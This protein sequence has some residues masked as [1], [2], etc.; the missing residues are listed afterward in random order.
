MNPQS[1][2]PA[3]RTAPRTGRQRDYLP[4]ASVFPDSGF[5]APGDCSAVAPAVFCCWATQ[6]H[7]PVILGQ[8]ANRAPR[9]RPLPCPGPWPC[10]GHP[11]WFI[12]GQVHAGCCV[13]CDC[14]ACFCAWSSAY[15]PEKPKTRA[16]ITTRVIETSFFIT[17]PF[18][19]DLMNIDS[20][21]PG[22]R[23]R[24]NIPYGSNCR[25]VER[26]SS[27]IPGLP[28][29]PK[30]GPA[31]RQHNPRRFPRLPGYMA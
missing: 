9:P 29:Q 31:S 27:G 17:I 26:S 1:T 28:L 23:A 16:T 6:G 22:G 19:V 11:A 30:D 13:C 25:F 15:T 8:F 12:L 3:P 18:L 14:C 24:R 7:C 21:A 2:H 20:D 4:F 5:E 10:Q